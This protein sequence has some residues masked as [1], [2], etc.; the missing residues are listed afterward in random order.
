[1][2]PCP[3]LALLLWLVGLLVCT[4]LGAGSPVP[5]TSTPQERYQNYPFGTDERV[6][7]IGIQPLWLPSSLIAVVMQRDGILRDALRQQGATVRFHPFLKGADLNIHLHSGAL[8]GGFAG[9]MPTLNACVTDRVQ[10]VSL[11]DLHFTSI[12]ARSVRTLSDLRGRRIGYAPGSNAHY[13]LLSA[14]AA[15]DL[16]ESEVTLLPMEVNVMLRAMEEGRIDAFSGWEPTTTLATK[17]YGHHVIHRFLS[18]GY[19]YFAPAFAERYADRVT[20]LV[21]AEFRALNWLNHSDDHLARAIDWLQQAVRTMEGHELELAPP[22]IMRLARR[23]LRRLQGMPLI[24]QEDLATEGRLARASRF[25]ASLDR[26]PARFDWDRVRACFHR[27]VGEQIL[28]APDHHR[29]HVFAY[30]V[31]E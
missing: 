17:L 12:V 18:S 5:A 15:E 14:L 24:P 2:K 20:L 6:V 8:E 23:T 16:S 4:P 19:L 7:D 29:L 1:M 10:V 3:A 30:E 9:D 31:A 27:A 11:A 21:A 26:D 28:S 13:A 22:E 25:L